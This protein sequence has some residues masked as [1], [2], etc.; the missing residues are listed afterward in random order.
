MFAF[1]IS[2][3]HH[4]VDVRHVPGQ[5]NLVTDRSSRQWDGLLREGNDGSKW[6]INEDWEDRTGIVNN[7]LYVSPT[8]PTEHATLVQ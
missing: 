4:I 3:T 6:T 1:S 8:P 2:Y 7:I 5:L